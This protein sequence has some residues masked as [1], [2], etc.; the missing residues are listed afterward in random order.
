M[1]LKK[2]LGKNIKQYRILRGFSQE[3][4]AEKIDISQQTLSRIECGKNFLT[5]ETLEKILSVLGVKINEL[6]VYEEEYSSDNVLED[7]EK[8]LQFL[9]SN[10]KKLACV[11][12]MIKEITFL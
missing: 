7:I 5:A 10:P 6:F 8:Y 12:K 1:N 2:I 4:F 3:E 11:H 9:K